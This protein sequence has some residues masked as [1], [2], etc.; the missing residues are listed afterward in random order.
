MHSAIRCFAEVDADQILTGSQTKQKYPVF[1]Q[2]DVDVDLL[3]PDHNP[4]IAIM[5]KTSCRERWKQWDRDAV[6][7][8]NMIVGLTTVGVLARE[9][10]GEDSVKAIKRVAAWQQKAAYCE[11]MLTVEDVPGMQQ[12]MRDIRESRA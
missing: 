10:K 8:K 11:R 9:K 3:L 1:S 4:P 6:I 12:L 5:C 2:R 7:A